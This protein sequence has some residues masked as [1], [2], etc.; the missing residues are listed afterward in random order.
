MGLFF[1]PRN[2]PGWIS[3]SKSLM[4][5]RWASAKRRT[6]LCACLMSSIVCLGTFEMLSWICSADNLKDAGDHLSNF[7]EYVRN[8]LSP[9]L[10]ISSM[11]P[12]TICDTRSEEAGVAVKT[13]DFRC[14][15]LIF[16][17]QV[18]DSVKRG[19]AVFQIVDFAER[20]T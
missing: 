1:W 14:L 11:T 7:S 12:W 13:A 5:A 16:V 4:L 15:T 10:R 17:V 9:F 6:L 8:A 3:T 2:T 19:V 18:L 20:K